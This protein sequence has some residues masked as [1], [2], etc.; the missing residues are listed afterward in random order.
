MTSRERVCAALDHRESDRVPVDFSGHRSS[1]IAASAYAQL[2]RFLG[3]PE[4]PIRMYDPVQQL[5]IVHEDVLDRFGVD[6]IELGRAFATDDRDW[7]DWILPDGT[8]CQM[9]AWAL[10]EREAAR[11]VIRSKTGRAIAAMPDG[12]LYFE[13]TYYPFLENDDLDA[14]PEAMDE[15]MWCA[16]A[17]PPGPLVAGPDGA[18]IL[19][20]GARE[21]RASTD[22]AIIGLFGGNLLEMGQFLW[23]NDVFL[24]L[25]AADP[26][27]IHAFLDKLMAIHLANL[28]TFLG[29]VGK[30]ID[31]VLF[32]DD[33]GMQQGP[34]IS[35]AMYREYFKPRH[36][37]LWSRAKELADVKIMLHC[38]GGVRELLPDLIEAGLDAINP[39]QISCAGMDAQGLKD[40]FGS[41][42]VFWGGGCDTQ[43]VLFYSTPEDVRRHV[44][45]QV[46]IL[47]PGGAPRRGGRG[48]GFVFQQVHNILTGVPPA[49]IVA[50]FD[51]VNAA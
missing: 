21:L 42:M 14:I 11:W 17:S 3:L 25:L 37:Q 34:Q 15:S 40:D 2:R 5:A 48:G 50:M 39:V 45:E 51:A 13:Q 35:P 19:E 10:P 38:C 46:R 32:G 43:H 18:E 22:K 23:R 12:A 26:P 49:N 27:K 30:H 28:D 44:L 6:T 9:P 4:K 16:I 36:K 24:M 7:A 31:I 29:A 20:R 1:G 41:E 8:P 33:L 47:S